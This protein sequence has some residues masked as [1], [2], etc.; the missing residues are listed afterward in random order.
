MAESGT[1]ISFVVTVNAS[2]IEVA[3]AIGQS[4]TGGG[5]YLEDTQV[6]PI[7]PTTFRIT[8]KYLPQWAIILG[9]IGLVFCFLGI[10]AVFFR[11]TEELIVDIQPDEAG[12]KIVVSGRT[13]DSI[14]TTIRSVLSR[15]PGYTPSMMNFSPTG[16]TVIPA[17]APR[18]PDGVYW[19]DG[20][21]WQLIPEDQRTLPP[22]PTA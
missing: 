6:V 15:F 14:A 13:K 19:W 1:E 8:R 7:G 21:A 9:I 2:P 17:N 16:S 12:S 5:N 11:D 4:V 10:I 22:P 18:S 20:A 3:T